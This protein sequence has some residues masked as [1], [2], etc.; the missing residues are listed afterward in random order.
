MCGIAGAFA[1]GGGAPPV[2]RAELQA[3]NDRMRPRG[4]DAGG[5]W[6]DGD[7]RVGLAARRLAI[8]DLS[9][10]GTQP[11]TDVDGE[12]R[13]VFNGEIY[14]HRE[15]R[16][17]LERFGAR[18]HSSSDTEVL[19]QLYRH[20]GEAMVDLLSGMY[21]FAIWDPRA[22]R[23]FIARDAYG[24]KPLYIADDGATLR[25]A[26]TV[27]ALL[28]GG[29][30][31]AAH[32]PAGVAGFWL[33]GS[34]PEPY[35]I[36]RSIRAVEAGT[37]FSVDE[38][39]GRAAAR[40]YYS[41][42]K[43]FA[44]AR[45]Q[46][47]I[48]E[49]VEPATLLRE[50]VTESLRYHL[51]SDVPV[52]A[53]L[54]A[55]I[56]STTLAALAAAAGQPP[57]CV[58]VTFDELRGGADDEAPLAERFARERGLPHTTRVVTRAE[59]RAELPKIF[60]AMDQPTIDG[61]NTWFVSK[62]ASEAGLKV[63]ISG[64]GGDELF[65]SYPA[66]RALPRLTR[67]ARLPLASLLA[68]AARNPKAKYV[69]RYAQT[70]AG[71]YVVKRGLFMPDDLPML[72]GRD[73]AAEAL[74][75]FDV[76]AHAAHAIEP[77]PETT[78]GRVA[79]LEASLYM[80]NQLL[81]DTDWASMAHSLEVRTPLVTAALLRQIAPLLLARGARC[82]QY[83]AASPEPPLPEWLRKRK[84]TGFSVPLKEWMELAPDGTSTRM[85]SW[86]RVV[87]EAFAL[88]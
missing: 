78:F 21:A 25:F 29:R 7:A 77:D 73:A 56:D 41:I 57:R 19:L 14:N 18:F 68:R 34:V 38:R 63:A 15:L 36:H 81:R 42:A 62:A 53:F 24:I 67:L 76:L 51:V 28:A 3:M 13:I 47:S 22:G 8:I 4:P 35:T 26:S 17:R 85:R 71:A 10:E 54:S 6:V 84:K 86:A 9:P 16:A 55:G 31:S 80:R 37:C 46:E 83:F 20:D 2:D 49:L 33:L 48:A 87:A 12:L 39:R 72:M 52:G 32:D 50:F 75:R 23:L 66:F 11:M 61:V 45:G 1:Y 64:L 40:P 82:K 5:I 88:S 58:T 65:G 60:D 30:V 70:Y 69:R 79:T 27:K 43:T 74:E 59:F 44:H